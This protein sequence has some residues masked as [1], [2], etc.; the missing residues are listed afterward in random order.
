MKWGALGI[1]QFYI[2]AVIAIRINID[3]NYH[4]EL[5]ILLNIKTYLMPIYIGSYFVKN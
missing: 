4:I 1:H 2:A 5:D 3:I